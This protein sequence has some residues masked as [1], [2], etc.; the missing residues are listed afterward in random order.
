MPKLKVNMT[1]AQF[2]GMLHI[3]GFA[4]AAMRRELR[5][6]DSNAWS[7]VSFQTPSQKRT[8]IIS[9]LMSVNRQRAS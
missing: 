5:M 1:G 7:A 3:L 4:A 9:A 6:A 8:R 2:W